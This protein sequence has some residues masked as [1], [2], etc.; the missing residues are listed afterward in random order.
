MI[1]TVA[2]AM[3]ESHTDSDH[4]TFDLWFQVTLGRGWGRAMVNWGVDA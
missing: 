3:T 1:A 4:S 2:I